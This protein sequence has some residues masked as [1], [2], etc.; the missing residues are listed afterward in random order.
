M[1]KMQEFVENLLDELSKKYYLDFSTPKLALKG[2]DELECVFWVM[3]GVID[4]EQCYTYFSMDDTDDYIVDAIKKNL[5]TTLLTIAQTKVMTDQDFVELLFSQPRALDRNTSY[6]LSDAYQTNEGLLTSLQ[7]A[8]YAI[9]SE[10]TQKERPLDKDKLRQ[11]SHKVATHIVGILFKRWC[12]ESWLR[13]HAEFP[14]LD[15]PQRA[16]LSLNTVNCFAS[17]EDLLEDT[18][19]YDIDLATLQTKIMKALGVKD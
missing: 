9:S 7:N 14:M 2:N 5:I 3:N 13:N 8:A 12:K 4:L 18:N 17:D 19:H 11:P 16:C 10:I 15:Y 1:D 6:E